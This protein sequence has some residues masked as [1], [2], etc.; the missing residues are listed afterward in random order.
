LRTKTVYVCLHISILLQWQY[1]QMPIVVNISFGG[2]TF[3]LT[4]AVSSCTSDLTSQV[5]R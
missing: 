3:V 1:G 2:G 4:A 5:M